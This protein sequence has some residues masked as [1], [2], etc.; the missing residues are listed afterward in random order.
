MVACAEVTTNIIVARSLYLSCYDVRVEPN[1]KVSVE[2]MSASVKMQIDR[3]GCKLPYLVS[4]GITV[5]RQ[6][7]NF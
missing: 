5:P 6:N 3:I 1:F 7:C 2:M 4:L